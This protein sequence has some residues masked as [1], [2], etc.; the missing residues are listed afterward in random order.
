MS[1]NQSSL[2]S[3]TFVCHNYLPAATATLTHLHHTPPTA[4]PISLGLFG[5]SHSFNVPP[6]G[7]E[8]ER[9]RDGEVTAQYT[10]A[11]PDCPS[12]PFYTRTL[13]FSIPSTRF[14]SLSPLHFYSFVCS[15]LLCSS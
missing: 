8:R 6:R 11:V 12:L 13:S 15:V 10:N 4:V 7:R 9:E 2:L 5:F 3:L 1:S 14:L